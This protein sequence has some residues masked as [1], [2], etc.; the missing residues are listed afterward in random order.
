MPSDAWHDCIVYWADNVS[1]QTPMRNDDSFGYGSS[2]QCTHVRPQT[3]PS[4]DSLSLSLLPIWM[5][6]FCCIMSTLLYAPWMPQASS[7]N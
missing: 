1:V 7:S 3:S 4:P 5:S 6:V 2:A